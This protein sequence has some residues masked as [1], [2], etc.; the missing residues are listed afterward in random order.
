MRY[1]A[2]IRRDP[3]ISP[4]YEDDLE[5]RA[6]YEV[7]KPVVEKIPSA[8]AHKRVLFVFAAGFAVMVFGI[9]RYRW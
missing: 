7:D 3:K 9:L 6:R 8:A 2:R 4:T 5:K 1:A